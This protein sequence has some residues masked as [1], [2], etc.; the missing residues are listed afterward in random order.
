[1]DRNLLNSVTEEQRRFH[2]EP[3]PPCTETQLER[4]AERVMAELARRLP[5]GYKDFLRLTNGLDWN[6]VVIF[7][8]ERIPITSNPDRFINGFVEMN[9]IYR[10]A[11]RFRSLVFGS[12]GMD[13]YTYD[14]STGTYEIHDEVSNDLIETLPSFDAMIT[15]ALTRC[16]R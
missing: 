14:Q 1:M 8:S 12:D 9:R 4:L 11:D 5:E 7:A 3:Q 13:V 15:K 10:D 6:G 16:L 2:C